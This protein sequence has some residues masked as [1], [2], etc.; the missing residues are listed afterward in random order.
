MLP[1]TGIFKFLVFILVTAVLAKP[2]GWYIAR[3]YD[4]GFRNSPVGLIERLIYRL[5]QIKTKQEMDWKAY[6][7]SMLWLNLFGFL[8]LYCLQRLQFYLP[9]NPNHFPGL[10]PAVAFNAA[11]SFITNTNWQAYSGEATMS[12]CTQMLGLTVQNFL[13]AATGLAML[14]ALIRGIA[15][16]ETSNLGNF[17]VDT[18]RATLYILLPLSS[19]L[20][21][22]LTSQGVVQN[23]KPYQKVALIQPYTYQIPLT[24]ALGNPA[25][26]QQSLPKRVEHVTTE[27]LLPM[28][29]AASQVAIKLLGSN[30][31]GFFNANSAHP[32]EN[33]TPL[34]NFLQMLAIL[35]IP[36]ALCYT[37]GIL[38]NDKRQGRAILIAMFM[39]F[40]P[41]TWVAMVA[42]QQGNPALNGLGLDANYREGI[43]AAGNMEGK[44]VRFGPVN[45][46]LFAVAATAS[47]NGSTNAMLDSYTP[48]GS[49]IP[50][51]MM[52]LGE[53]VFGGV[54][55]GLYSML[56]LIIITVFVAGLM[57]GRTPEYLGKKIEPFEM[58]MASF[59]ILVMPLLVLI[60]TA[61]GV[62]LAVG[63]QAIFNPGAH[64]FSEVLYAF[65]SMANNNGSAFAG[66]NANSPFYCL[67]GGLVMLLGRYWI[68]I[69]VLAIAGSLAKKK[70]IP[71][72]AG[73]MT[74]YT[75]LFIILLVVV[76]VIIGALVFF[77]ALSLGLIAEQLI[78]WGQYGH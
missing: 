31:G 4:G 3:V 44:E 40:I 34:S 49:M 64:G 36:A 68:A 65:T 48:L 12:Y 71:S 30:G 51:W 53:V 16:Q 78:I 32:Y 39:F 47:S 60:A 72:S 1:G 52:Q 25:P 46:A 66:L 55:S 35:I 10:T 18:V 2:L 75:P 56:M 20:A 14:M 73:T 41:F 74:T 5:C 6:L 7:S 22:I 38:V 21:I 50:L 33:P 63:K 54:G 69:P 42:E 37:F 27:Q 19:L 77:P 43:Y 62:V 26:D 9:F 61:A 11:A 70:I 67:L 15:K 57:V 29:P 28:G 59:A 8:L 76:A 24:D 45:S 13:S 17:W 23:F 58:K